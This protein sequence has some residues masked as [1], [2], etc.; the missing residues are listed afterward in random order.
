LWPPI[1]SSNSRR[2]SPK[3]IAVSCHTLKYLTKKKVVIIQ[4]SKY[5]EQR[6]THQVPRLFLCN[7]LMTCCKNLLHIH[8][9]KGL[10]LKMT[11]HSISK[12]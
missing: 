9:R 2:T 11:K 3:G 1:Q 7:K 5:R 6:N 8:A 12:G 10:L 4:N